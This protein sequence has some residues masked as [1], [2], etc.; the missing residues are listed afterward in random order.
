MLY[1]CRMKVFQ[2]NQHIKTLPKVDD[3]DPFGLM[4]SRVSSVAW[5]ALFSHSKCRNVFGQK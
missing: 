5:N 3:P 1:F 2:Y 4:G